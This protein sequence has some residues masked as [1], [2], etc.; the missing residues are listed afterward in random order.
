MP[1]VIVSRR[2][3]RHHI[4]VIDHTIAHSEGILNQRVEVLVA[5]TRAAVRPQVRL[6][7][8]ST[9]IDRGQGRKSASQRMAR[10]N[11][12][13]RRILDDLRPDSREHRVLSSTREY[14]TL[15]SSKRGG[16]VQAVD[17]LES[18]V[19]LLEARVNLHARV[20]LIGRHLGEL[21]IGDPVPQRIS[22]RASEA[23]EDYTRATAMQPSNE[24]NRT[25]YL[26]ILLRYWLALVRASI[27]LVLSGA[28][29]AMYAKPSVRRSDAKPTER[30]EAPLVSLLHQV[31]DQL[32]MSDLGQ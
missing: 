29:A 3:M 11:D 13:V 12:A 6:R 27:V 17:Y 15:I 16:R 10:H 26:S 5:D 23:H 2:Q 9:D 32:L 1:E 8:Q 4:A 31:H 25:R 28:D 20:V 14:E 21:E 7:C 19:G 24:L 22:L 18:H 30:N